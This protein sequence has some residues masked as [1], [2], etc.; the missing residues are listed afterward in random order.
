MDQFC[1]DIFIN[2]KK[3]KLPTSHLDVDKGNL[4]KYICNAFGSY[5]VYVISRVRSK[6]P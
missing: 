3:K 5:L 1:I 4:D 6:L 2:N